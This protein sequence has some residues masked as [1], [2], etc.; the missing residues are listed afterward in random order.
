MKAEPKGAFLHSAIFVLTAMLLTFPFLNRMLMW[1]FL[2][3]FG[4]IHGVQEWIK[5]ELCVKYSINNIGILIL[6]Q[7]LHI[8][9]LATVL[10]S[11]MSREIPSASST[12]MGIYNNNNVVFYAMGYV[13]SAFGSMITI[14]YLRKMFLGKKTE[15]NE[16]LSPIEQYYGA[17]ERILITTLALLKGNYFVFIPMLPLIRYIILFN[18]KR[19]GKRIDWKVNTIEIFLSVSIAACIGLILRLL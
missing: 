13:I 8:G 3:L 6:D 15:I 12:L 16:V 4:I 18:E 1:D 5:I 14:V 10:I 11:P 7:I 17:T 2:I 19:K 9:I